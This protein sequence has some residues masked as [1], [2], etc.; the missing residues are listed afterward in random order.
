[1][2]TSA[3]QKISD[4]K[5]YQLLSAGDP[6][7][8]ELYNPDGKAPFL[9]VCEHASNA[10]PEKMKS[11]VLSHKE[12]QRHIAW[13]IG[14]KEVAKI[15]ADHFDAKLISAGYSR[16]LIDC[17]RPIKDETSIPAVSDGTV[18]P[19]NS[20]LTEEQK[21]QRADTFFWSYHNAIS[22][23]IKK[24][25]NTSGVP[26]I[27]TVHSFCSGLAV[28]GK[29]RPWLIDVMWNRDVRIA[30]PLLEQMRTRP[31]MIVGDN[32]PYSG[33]ESHYTIG[34]HAG[35]FGF[36]HV[37]LEIRQDLI[38]DKAG[39]EFWADFLVKTLSPVLESTDLYKEEFF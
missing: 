13:D 39:C 3:M 30:L 21:K 14:A 1:M 2:Y 34:A 5:K 26:A 4:S 15:L 22:A 10:I 32:E 27:I 23:E 33:R 16:L 25:R 18:I 7:L 37:G 8:W 12:L 36:P 35:N 9:L 29:S 24:L 11:L 6:P 19:G 17:N 28:H 38:S 20:N 31:E